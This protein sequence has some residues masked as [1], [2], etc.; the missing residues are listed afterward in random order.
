MCV[1]FPKEPSEALS[2]H[3]GKKRYECVFLFGFILFFFS[4]V[5]PNKKE[6]DSTR[7]LSLFQIGGRGKEKEGDAEKRKGLGGGLG[8][9][10]FFSVFFFFFLVS[11]LP[12]L[13]FY[14]Y[15]PEPS[16]LLFVVC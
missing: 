9:L 14:F 8:V 1:L 16:S 6:K 15:F 2:C 12:C 3:F 7:K 5:A 10:S 13:F 4:L 11:R